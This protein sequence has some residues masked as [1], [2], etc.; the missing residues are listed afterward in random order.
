MY[1]YYYYENVEWKICVRLLLC[2]SQSGRYVYV[3]DYVCLLLL[4]RALERKSVRCLYTVVMLQLSV[5]VCLRPGFVEAVTVS[6]L[7]HAQKRPIACT[8]ETYCMR[9]RDLLHAQKRP[10]ACCT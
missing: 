1:V 9:K 7:L 8:K 6:S 3:Y 2:I 4:R 5:E 10:I